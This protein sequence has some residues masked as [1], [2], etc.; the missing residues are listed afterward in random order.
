MSN[1][2]PTTVLKKPVKRPKR[3]PPVD[4]ARPKRQFPP[5]ARHYAVGSSDKD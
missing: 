3:K 4:V 1:I 5:G 2:K